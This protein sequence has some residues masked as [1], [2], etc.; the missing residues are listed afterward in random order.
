MSDKVIIELQLQVDQAGQQA[1]AV[2]EELK[3]V[4][5]AAG[6]T[7]TAGKEAADKIS[8]GLKDVAKNSD[9]TKG[10]VTVLNDE[11]RKITGID[12]K[13]IIGGITKLKAEFGLAGEA[14]KKQAD[15][16]KLL[17]NATTLS[18]RAWGA[19]T[20]AV[21]LFRLALISTGIGAI[22][23]ALGALAAA[24]LT[25]EKGTDA[26]TR[27]FKP[28]ATVLQR[29]LGLFQ[30]I[31][32][33]IINAFKDPQQAV[34]DLVKLV[35][36]NIINRFKAIP[37]LFKAI[38]ESIKSGL[39][40]DIEGVKKALTDAGQAVIQFGTGID[41]VAQN[42]IGNIFGEALKDGQRLVEIGIELEELA[43]NREL[44]ENRLKKLYEEQLA[45]S[46]NY[47]LSA[48]E[49]EAAANNAI[50]FQRELADLQLKEVD[51]LIEQ[52]KI[53]KAQNSSSRADQ[54]EL[55]DLLARREEI[56]ENFLK[57][58]KQVR[59]QINALTL[60]QA[61]IEEKAQLDRFNRESEFFAL[62][63]RYIQELAVIAD[64][65]LDEEF[66][67]Y[68]KKAEE[69]N[70]KVQK[71]IEQRDIKFKIEADPEG[72]DGIINTAGEVLEGIEEPLLGLNERINTSYEDIAKRAAEIYAE[73]KDAGITQQEAYEQAVKESSARIL[74]IRAAEAQATFSVASDLFGQLSGLL[75]KGSAEAKA[76]ALLSIIFKTAEGVAGA[77]AAGAGVAFPANLVAIASGIAAVLSGIGQAKQVLSQAGSFAEGTDYLQRG[78]NPTGRDTIP[79]WADEG[80]AIIP[81][82]RNKQ[83]QG[84]A[85]A[86]RTGSVD[87]WVNR[88]YFKDR[89]ANMRIE[90]SNVNNLTSSLNDKNIVVGLRH[91]S[92][93]QDETNQLLTKLAKS[94]RFKRA[95]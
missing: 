34:K 71:I 58:T 17:T 87:E 2:V 22:V 84:L 55:N 49:R 89:L 36:D 47:T 83:Y 3:K 86:F 8:G 41:K 15:A 28:L 21:K 12:F 30:E 62:R 65:A 43:A 20:G 26:L 91:V 92:R 64:N 76:A 94:N 14:V 74:A 72:L 75:R 61:K 7:G 16:T 10:A 31:G 68:L 40:G 56:E 11:V 57:K 5:D 69:L 1:K 59:G 13:S 25:T 37:L 19:V 82:R 54:K 18:A 93:R 95:G 79:I 51:L 53:N 9:L 44:Q 39:T 70:K 27:V 67:A 24:L 81:R 33:A 46:T 73:Q 32:F 42:K 66:D 88:Y 4:E 90:H 50:G 63:Q 77:V 52:A 35:T 48:K 29:A 80:E 38:G 6:K 85:K 60:A 45:I 78:N 23:V